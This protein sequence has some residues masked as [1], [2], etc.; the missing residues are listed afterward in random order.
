[1]T[2]SEAT[3]YAKRRDEELRAGDF[4]NAVVWVTLDSCH[5]V[6]DAIVEHKDEYWFLFT[7]HHGFDVHHD[8]E[9]VYVAE[10]PMLGAKIWKGL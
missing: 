5:M 9:V 6:Q 10:L 1:M 4:H 2:I 3:A 8:D 7:E